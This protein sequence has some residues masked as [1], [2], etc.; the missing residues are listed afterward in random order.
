[1][2]FYLA[3]QLI[4]S[5]A[6]NHTDSK[7]VQQN[8]CWTAQ[9]WTDIMSTWTGKILPALFLR[10]LGFSVRSI[11][12]SKMAAPNLST[13]RILT[14]EFGAHASVMVRC[15][16]EVIMRSEDGEHFVMEDGRGGQITVFR[17]NLEHPWIPASK[18]VE[19]IGQVLIL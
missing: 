2:I 13:P 6:V 8:D 18:Y 12:Q 7:T 19:V 15:V 16:G 10:L 14:S 3:I 4:S 9:T 5:K 11:E 1:M 17:W